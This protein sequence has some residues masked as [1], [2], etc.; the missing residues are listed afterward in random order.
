MLMEPGAYYRLQSIAQRQGVSVAELVR[1]AVEERYLGQPDRRS[2][3]IDEI[4]AMEFPIAED[5]EVLEAEIEEAR[6]DG[7]P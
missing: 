3:L 7:L 6:V 1:R 5:W 4:L 2:E